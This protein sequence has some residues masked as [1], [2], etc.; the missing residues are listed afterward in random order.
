MTLYKYKSPTPFERIADILTNERLYCAPYHQLN[1]PFEGIFMESIRMGDREFLVRTEPEDLI[2]PEDALKA[3]VCSLSSDGSSTLLWSFY[4]QR[5]EGVCF[6]IDCDDLEPSP[7][8]VIYPPDIPRFDKHG[9]APSV[10]YALSHKSKEWD[11]EQN[12]GS[13]VWTNTSP[14]KAAS[15]KRYSGRAATKP[16]RRLSEE[17]APRECDVCKAKLDRDRRAIVIA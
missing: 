6:E 16:P 7:H 14:S 12:T 10:A 4:A 17:L 2:D 9:F 8:K 1:D 13:S 11:F 3:R 5:L 15:K